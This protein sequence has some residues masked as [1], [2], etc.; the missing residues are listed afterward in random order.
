MPEMR[1]PALL[2]NPASGRQ[3]AKRL[4]QVEAAA[5]VLRA[6][7]VE[8]LLIATT[9]PNSAGAQARE[10]IAGGCDAVI[11]CGGDGTVNDVLQ[12]IAGSDMPLGVIPLG[13]GNAL[14]HDLRI[15]VAPAGAAR[16]LLNAQPRPVRIAEADYDG[17][18]RYWMVAA[19]VGSD[20][21]MIYRVATHHKQRFGLYAYYG[22]GFAMWLRPRFIPFLTEFTDSTSGQRRTEKLTQMLAVRVSTFGGI[23]RNLGPGAALDRD[24]LRLVLIRGTSRIPYLFHSIRAMLLGNWN[25]PGVEL[26]Y[27]RDVECRPENGRKV[28]AEVDGEL[29]GTVPVRMRISDLTVNLLYPKK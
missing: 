10:A 7:G 26:V 22:V 6:G 25:V 8:P 24:D 11:A 21:L 27:A 15:A 28:Y 14:A 17:R 13:S 19:G 5:A 18:R 1:K 12:G 4:A 23:L 9:G 20:A 3:R 2:Y 29:L 16:L